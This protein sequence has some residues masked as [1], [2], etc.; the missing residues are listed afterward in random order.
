MRAHASTQRRVYLHVGAPKTGTT[1]LQERLF[2]NAPRLARHGVLVPMTPWWSGRGALHFRAALDLL[3]QDWGGPPGHARGAWQQ[4]LEQV[5]RHD[6]TAVISHE[7]LAPAPPELVARVMADLGDAE[8]HIVYT[9]RDLARLLPSAWQEA[10]KQGREMRFARFLHRARDNDVWFMQAFDLPAVLGTWG[11]GLPPERL[12]VV[13]V[14]RSGSDPTLLWRRFCAAIGVDPD[15]APE[16]PER[17]NESLG[18]PETQVLR[19]LNRR[20]R[21]RT[22]HRH[23]HVVKNLIAQQGLAQRRSAPVR[24]PPEQHDWV[25]ERSGEWI[26]WARDRGIDVVGDLEELRPVPPPPEEPWT[27]PDVFRPQ[28]FREA[29]LDA[30]A[31]AVTVAAERDD[32]DRLSGKL[33]RGRRRVGDLVSRRRA[34]SG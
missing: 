2:A 16:E 17:R 15:W 19:L 4:L 32:Q 33:R 7:L 14:P 28:D 8:V 6:G 34:A 5:R 12:H 13:T 29:A 27:D 18:I 1:Y 25:A 26:A 3:G 9:A 10:V 24:L 23:R 11:A 22:D 30:L 21:G 20:L 31:I